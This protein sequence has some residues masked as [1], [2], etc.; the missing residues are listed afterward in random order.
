MRMFNMYYNINCY[1]AQGHS[2][3]FGVKNRTLII[4]LLVS[5]A[6]AAINIYELNIPLKELSLF[7][8]KF[9]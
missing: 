6:N 7:R 8:I 5:V 9:T 4:R 2:K 3:L 1:I